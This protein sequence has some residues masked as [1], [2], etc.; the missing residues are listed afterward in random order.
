MSK[1][2]YKARVKQFKKMTWEGLKEEN[3]LDGSLKEIS[4]G[5]EN[6]ILGS[7]DFQLGKERKRK[8][9]IMSIRT[10]RKRILPGKKVK[11]AGFIKRDVICRKI[12]QMKS[13][14]ETGLMIRLRNSGIKMMWR[15]VGL[16]ICGRMQMIQR[17]IHR[18]QPW[19]GG[20]SRQRK[21]PWQKICFIAHCRR[22]EIQ[23]E[24]LIKRLRIRHPGGDGSCMRKM[25]ASDR[26]RRNGRCIRER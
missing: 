4:T 17:K 24:V 23:A 12:Q 20:M 15:S 5:S 21:F 19:Q 18:I 22:K 14:V 9:N 11:N 25:P 6:R 26:K 3:P 13:A 10:S 7:D 1:K 16:H 8:S 2:E